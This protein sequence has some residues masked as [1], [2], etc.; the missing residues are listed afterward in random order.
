MPEYD[1]LNTNKMLDATI[2]RMQ[3]NKRIGLYGENMRGDRL[4]QK[5][6][7]DLQGRGMGMEEEKFDLLKKEMNDPLLKLSKGIEYIKKSEALG[8]SREQALK[9]LQSNP[10][11]I[12]YFEDVKSEHIKFGKAGEAMVDVKNQETGETIGVAL[13]DAEGKPHMIE[14]DIRKMKLP[15]PKAKTEKEGLSAKFLMEQ[16]NKLEMSKQ[17]IAYA[18]TELV[19]MGKGKEA[20]NLSKEINSIDQ[21]IKDLENALKNL[22]PEEYKATYGGAPAGT[23]TDTKTLQTNPTK[24]FLNKKY[25]GDK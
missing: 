25:E 16:K 6:L 24:Y 13:F 7:L 3:E 20:G 17:N 15:E 9:S 8:I 11:Y 10:D 4:Y 14:Y 21:S 23:G 2:G 18:M 22:H 12:N 5:G 1:P 19:R